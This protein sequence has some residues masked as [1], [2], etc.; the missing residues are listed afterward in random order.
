MN[1]FTT[2]NFAILVAIFSVLSTGN[3]EAQ[4][5]KIDSLTPWKK[6]FKAGLNINQA[7]FSSN[8]KAGGVNSIGINVFLNYKVDYSKGKDTWN[9]EFDFLFGMVNNQGLGYRKTLDRIFIDSKYG[10]VLSKHWNLFVA[11]NIQS[12]F[13]KGYKYEKDANGVDQTKLTSSTLSPLFTTLSVGFEYNP[14]SYFH[15]RISP[16]A[17]RIT[18][19]NSNDGRFKFVDPLKPYGVEVNKSSRFELASFLLTM[20]FDK[21]LA[22]NL[23]LK[24]RYLLYA[25]YQTLEGKLIDHRFDI[26]LVTKVAKFVNV[27]LNGIFLYD[28]DQDHSPQLSQSFSLGFLYTFQN[29]KKE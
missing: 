25:N 1:N 17:P 27:S 29:Y 9:N 15:I 28:Y 7:S 6:S 4:I 18:Y 14:V 26:S 24:W 23:N 21:D 13:A 22:P 11:G 2:I 5:V 12:Q 20:D 16:L 8:W 19:L 10:R 3:L